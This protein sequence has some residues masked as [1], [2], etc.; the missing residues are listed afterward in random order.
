M[1]GSYYAPDKPQVGKLRIYMAVPVISRSK[2]KK[3]YY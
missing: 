2:H 1:R 3:D